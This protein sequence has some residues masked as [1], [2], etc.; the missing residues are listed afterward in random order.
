MRDQLT[1]A[2]I[3]SLTGYIRPSAQIRAL[4]KM[5]IKYKIRPRDGSPIVVRECIIAAMGLSAA[6]APQEDGP[7]FDKVA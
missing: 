6:P 3:E 7:R 2:E 5:G 1:E 4:E